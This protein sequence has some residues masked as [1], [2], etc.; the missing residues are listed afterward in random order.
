MRIPTN[1]IILGQP[2]R[3]Y[4]SARH[5]MDRYTVV[6]MH[7]PEKACSTYSAIGMDSRPFHPQGVGMHCAAMP[8]RHLGK[9]IPF[10]TLPPDCQ[11][12]VLQ[13]LKP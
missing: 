5:G 13:D 12:A 6:Y 10:S 4:D 11:K 8:G 7:W 9:R 1:E 3:C 2:V